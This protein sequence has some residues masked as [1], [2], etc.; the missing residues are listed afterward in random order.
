MH[1][2][3]SYLALG[4]LYPGAKSFE[5]ESTLAATSDG[6]Y[7]KDLSWEETDQY[8]VGL[9]L[10]FLNY[11]LGITLDY[12]YRYTDKMLMKVP[13]PGN[14][15]GYTTQWRNAAAVSNEVIEL[16]VKYEIFLKQYVY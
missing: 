2:D 9:D 7:N 1:F 14:Y 12:Y 15:N 16:L 6:L 13:L 8:D 3:Q 11:R 5:G 4:V 10:D